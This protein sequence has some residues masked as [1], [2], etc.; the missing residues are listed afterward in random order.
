MAWA[1][2]KDRDLSSP[3]RVIVSRCLRM[4]ALTVEAQRSKVKECGEWCWCCLN[5]KRLT[6]L[7]SESLKRETSVKV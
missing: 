6:I 1:L 2:S 5:R 3:E 4:V 7:V